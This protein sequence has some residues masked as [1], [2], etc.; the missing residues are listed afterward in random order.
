LPT[1]SSLPSYRQ[2]CQQTKEGGLG[3]FVTREFDIGDIIGHFFGGVKLTK[4]NLDPVTHTI[5]CSAAYAND[6]IQNPERNNAEITTYTDGTVALRV[7]KKI[8]QY[9]EVGTCYGPDQWR[10]LLYPLSLLLI[11]QK[12]YKKEN[13]PE[14]ITLIAIKRAMEEN[15]TPEQSTPIPNPNPNPNPISSTLPP[16][17]NP[18]QV[19]IPSESLPTQPE[20]ILDIEPITHSEHFTLHPV[21]DD[22]ETH[23]QHHSSPA[24]HNTSDETHQQEQVMNL[25]M[26]QLELIISFSFHIAAVNY[27]QSQL[28]HHRHWIQHQLHQL[29][30]LQTNKPKLQVFSIIIQLD[31]DYYITV[32]DEDYNPEFHIVGIYHMLYYIPHIGIFTPIDDNH[33]QLQ[34]LITHIDTNIV[35]KSTLMSYVTNSPIVCLISNSNISILRIKDSYI[36]QMVLNSNNIPPSPSPKHNTSSRKRKR[37]L[38]TSDAARTTNYNWYHRNKTWIAKK[39]KTTHS[40]PGAI[41]LL[42]QHPDADI[43]TLIQTYTPKPQLPTVNISTT[44]KTW[45]D[46]FTQT[47]RHKLSPCLPPENRIISNKRKHDESTTTSITKFITSTKPPAQIDKPVTTTQPTQELKTPKTIR[48][49]KS[50]WYHRNKDIISIKNKEKADKRKLEELTTTKPSVIQ[51]YFIKKSKPNDDDTK[52]P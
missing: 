42:N 31:L 13:D 48:H 30:I 28:L 37:M 25:P 7:I 10:T 52:P 23:S 44:T 8:F 24:P 15:D 45:S 16:S 40:K 51:E 11:A 46:I 18:A 29:R 6:N 36:Q 9:E 50:M 12:A 43:Q 5:S 27:L 4:D 17:Y 39:Y 32:N 19:P 26:E 47:T 22:S 14:W 3:L 2:I 1:R 20:Q 41:Q 21:R 38:K 33:I 35:S 49:N 34:H